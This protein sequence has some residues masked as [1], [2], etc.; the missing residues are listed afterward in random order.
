[1]EKPEY[2]KGPTLL[3][4]MGKSWQVVAEAVG[5]FVQLRLDCARVCV[6][7]SENAEVNRAI[8]ELQSYWKRRGLPPLEVY[9]VAGFTDLRTEQEHAQFTEG[10]LR[11][12]FHVCP[13]RRDRY[14]CLAGGFK[15]MSA[16]MQQ[17]ACWFGAAEVFHVLCEP[18]YGP[19]GNQEPKSAEDV[20]QALAAGHVRSIRLG[21]ESGWPQ[22]LQLRAEDFPL[23]V[24]QRDDTWRIH[25]SSSHAWLLKSVQEVVQRTHDLAGNFCSLERFPFASLALWPKEDLEWLRQPLDPQR[26]RDWLTALPKVELHCH[27]GGFATHGESLHKV[28][29]A[30]QHPECLP[31]LKASDYPTG[32][33]KPP[34][35]IAL[36][37]Y[38]RLG[39]NNGSRLLQDPGCLRAQCA[40]LYEALVADNV[41]YA[42]TRCSPVNYQNQET[43]RSAWDVLVDIRN[44]F[45]ECMEKTS[46]DRRCHVSLILV[47]TR[48]EGEDRSA[49]SRHLSLA[50]VA[51]DYW[52]TGCRVVGVDLAGFETKETRASVF[53]TDFT[54]VHRV[55][56]AVTVHAGENDDVEGIWQAVFHLS[57]RRLGHAL[58][59][60]DAP[61]LLATV[62][63]RRIGVEMCPYANLQIKGFRLPGT[64]CASR[65]EYPLQRYMRQNVPVTVNTDNIG[66]SAASLTDNLALLV[67][68]R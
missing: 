48:R 10:L 60:E 29:K 68:Q 63:A 59:L 38:M 37:A 47:A 66:I 1:M 61:D 32:W 20:D 2:R 8:K 45:Q 67:L 35:P 41:R 42:E 7:T 58:H 19:E 46:G 6:L 44:T 33:P 34:R 22:L 4:S 21:P 11:W 25:V 65:P 54:P 56:L 31:A 5:V 36:D 55:G 9:Q 57:A 50:I 27:L 3:C 53:A 16:A 39:D 49:I 14:V 13:D 51:R 24:E 30:A 28:R 26:D 12:M 62:A 40:L 15:T 17:A 52:P 64:E 23:H 18:R 43:G